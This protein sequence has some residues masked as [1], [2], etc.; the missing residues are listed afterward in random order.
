[1]KLDQTRGLFEHN[2]NITSHDTCSLSVYHQQFSITCNMVSLGCLLCTPSPLSKAASPRQGCQGQTGEGQG[3]VITAALMR[4]LQRQTSIEP[5]H[6]RDICTLY[7]KS[8]YN[9][10]D[11]EGE[12]TGEINCV[13]FSIYKLSFGVLRTSISD[14][15]VP[16]YADSPIN[17]SFCLLPIGC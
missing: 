16:A 10:D 4:G 14:T 9:N 15:N 12:D 8:G 17:R 13:I 6:E 3:S 1:M 5:L 2:E 7:L 11:N